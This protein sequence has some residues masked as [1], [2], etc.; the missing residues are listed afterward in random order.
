[1][2][3]VPQHKMTVDEFLAWVDEFPGRYELI[4]G[5]PYAM[6]PERL[7]H[8]KTKFAVQS[9]L[10]AAIRREGL[11]CNMVPDGAT[12]RISERTAYE[13]DA[14]VYCGAEIPDDAI[15]V[16][17]PTIVVEVLSPG[18]KHV[19]N[20]AKLTGYFSLPSVRHYLILDIEKK[21]IIHHARGEGD[22]IMTR[23]AAEGSL[24]LDPPGLDL[25]VGACFGQ[26]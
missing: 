4:D 14:L 1:M 16:P 8:A 26:R 15:E 23:I 9:A 7:G 25:E 6:S 17:A 20:A 10:L 19:D 13:P 2:S 11:A 21:L 22:L 5:V 24:K 18:T 3:A 12:V